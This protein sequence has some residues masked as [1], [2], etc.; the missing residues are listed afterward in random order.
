ME[1]PLLTERETAKLLNCSVAFLR[2]FRLIRQ[3]PPF[4][5]LGR[6]VRYRVQDLEAYITEN[7]EGAA[8]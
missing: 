3:G 7:T 2:R 6:L 4:I 1:N 5:K 8:A